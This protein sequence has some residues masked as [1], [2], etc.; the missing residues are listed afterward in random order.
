[1]NEIISSFSKADINEEV[2]RFKSHLDLVSKLDR[3]QRLNWKKIR[4]LFTRDASRD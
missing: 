4:F 3:L 1:M 2:V